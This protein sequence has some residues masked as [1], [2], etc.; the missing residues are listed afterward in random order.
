MQVVRQLVIV[1][2]GLPPQVWS[3]ERVGVEDYE[4]TD[5]IL[6]VTRILKRHTPTEMLMINTDLW[7]VSDRRLTPSEARHSRR[8]LF[9]VNIQFIPTKP[10]IRIIR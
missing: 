1:Y 3:V 4:P 5:N 7:L 8:L 9:N 10:Y 6:H 2:D